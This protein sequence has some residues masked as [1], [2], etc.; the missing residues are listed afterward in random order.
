[1][2]RPVKLRR[3]ASSAGAT[4]NAGGAACGTTRRSGQSPAGA[5]GD[6]RHHARPAPLPGGLGSLKTTWKSARPPGASRHVEI[7]LKGW[8]SHRETSRL[9]TRG[10]DAP[11]RRR[12][13]K[14]GA[15]TRRFRI[16][17]ARECPAPSGG[18]PSS[19]RRSPCYRSRWQ[20][21]RCRSPPGSL[22]CLPVSR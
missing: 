1:M 2:H 9:P 7:S 14:G 10:A 16:P 20:R 8:E 19:S 17:R 6:L 11:Q 21:L 18:S 4:R 15:V 3:W 22:Q 13:A 12:P 5:E